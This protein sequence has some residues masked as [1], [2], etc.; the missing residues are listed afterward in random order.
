MKPPVVLYEPL[1]RLRTDYRIGLSAW[2]DKSMLAE[3]HFYPR[4]TMTAEER[5]WWYSR[6]FDMVEVNST[7]YALPAAETAEAWSARTPRGFLFN[8][9]A[10][11]LLTGHHVDLARLPEPLRAMLPRRLQTAKTSRVPATAFDDEARAWALAE[12][13]RGIEPLRRA[14]KLGYLL[15]QLAPWMKASDETKA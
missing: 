9:K 8:V 12:L 2:T 5:L 10:L 14:D 3:G 7:F 13:R 11:G 6:F 4:K 1:E 15:F